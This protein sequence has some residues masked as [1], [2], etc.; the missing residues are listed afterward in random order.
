M[1]L[2]MQVVYLPEDRESKA[3]AGKEQTECECE[4]EFRN[5]QIQDRN[6]SSMIQGLVGR[7]QAPSP[8]TSDRGGGP[9]LPACSPAPCI[10]VSHT[11][12]MPI[13]I[14]MLAFNLSL[15]AIASNCLCV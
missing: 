10:I 13:H 1:Q 9:A 15:P 4:C 5:G 8:S 3:A 14:S 7:C 2:L 6:K 11:I 12:E